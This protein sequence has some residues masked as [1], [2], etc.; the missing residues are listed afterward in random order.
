MSNT[1]LK[2]YLFAFKMSITF[3][4]IS[5]EALW[6]CR[7]NS[8]YCWAM[9]ICTITDKVWY[10]K[11]QNEVNVWYLPYPAW[12]HWPHCTGLSILIPLLLL[13]YNVL[14]R[15]ISSNLSYKDVKEVRPGFGIP[16]K[17]N[18]PFF[19]NFYVLVLFIFFCIYLKTYFSSIEQVSK[20]RKVFLLWRFR[21]K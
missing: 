3:V 14:N 7:I 19:R 5:R 12:I 15:K 9:E 2:C 21:I 20:I 13:N 4:L 16:A 18:P 17:F 8:R 10:S 1:R 11:A 6:L